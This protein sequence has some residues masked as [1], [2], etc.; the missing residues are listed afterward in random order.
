M[1][2]A[3]SFLKHAGMGLLGTRK[4]KTTSQDIGETIIVIGNTPH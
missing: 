2:A 1:K 4:G 3:Y